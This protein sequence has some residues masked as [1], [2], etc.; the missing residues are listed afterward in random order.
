M[1]GVCDICSTTST[2]FVAHSSAQLPKRSG[3]VCLEPEPGYVS[4]MQSPTIHLSEYN[5]NA[6]ATV[7]DRR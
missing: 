1:H 6:S 4:V 7:Y 3:E 2:T 5:F